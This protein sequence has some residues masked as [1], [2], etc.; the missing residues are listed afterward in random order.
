MF[1]TRIGILGPGTVRC[2]ACLAAALAAGCAETTTLWGDGATCDDSA[3]LDWCHDQGFPTGVCSHDG[4]VCGGRED[5]GPTCNAVACNAWCVTAGA[6]YGEC[7]GDECVCTPPVVTDADADAPDDGATPDDASLPETTGPCTPGDIEN[8]P[9]GLRCGTISRTCLAGGTWG[10]WSDCL[11]EGECSAGATDSRTC[12]CGGSESRTCN[13]SC[14]WGS[15]S[16]CPSGIC[17]PGAVE[18]RDCSCGSSRESRTCTASCTWGS[19]SGCPVP[20]HM[21]TGTNNDPCSEAYNTW[22][23]AWDTRICG[24]WV[25]Q[26]CRGGV[27]VSYHC[28]PADCEGCCPAYSSACE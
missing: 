14:T 28:S 18:Y 15:W 19:W 27:W 22:R 23:C 25:S 20:T 6:D 3:C 21:G 12:A 13:S 16:G 1:D 26:V 9:C 17:S 2:A 7:H 24:G 10:A 8:V 4:C 5:G 11:G